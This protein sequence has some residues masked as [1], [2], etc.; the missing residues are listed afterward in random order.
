LAKHRSQIAKT[1][2]AA[3]LEDAYLAMALAAGSDG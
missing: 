1:A 2:F 3:K